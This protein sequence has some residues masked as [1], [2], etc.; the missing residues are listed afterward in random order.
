MYIHKKNEKKECHRR[1]FKA[2]V[3]LYLKE[4][5]NNT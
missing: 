5:T 4:T 2:K 3:R 1:V